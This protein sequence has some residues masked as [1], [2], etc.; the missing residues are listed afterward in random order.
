MQFFK[1]NDEEKKIIMH[2]LY[3][4]APLNKYTIDVITHRH[5]YLATAKQMNDEW[6]FRT[7]YVQH[8]NRVGTLSGMFT[9]WT[10]VMDIDGDEK[11]EP[12]QDQNDV[13]IEIDSENIES[14]RENLGIACFT[15]GNNNSS[16]WY[17]YADCYKGVCLEFTDLF[18]EEENF[19]EG[20]FGKVIYDKYPYWNV[21]NNKDQPV[22]LCCPII[23][24]FYK[25]NE[26]K[27]ENEYRYVVPICMGRDRYINYN[28]TVLTAIYLGHMMDECDKR[29]VYDL[30][31]AN[32][33]EVKIFNS[34]VIENNFGY[35]FKEYSIIEL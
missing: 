1:L 22:P 21:S 10:A 33:S 15:T 7:R 14:D 34:N 6:E 4:Y 27:C 19:K 8:D 16:M 25:S 13:L 31:H 17:H 12:F 30:A 24:L 18:S 29:L 5:I 28:S 35:N 11:P 23:R 20:V 26:W 3:R 2:K 9:G 32:N